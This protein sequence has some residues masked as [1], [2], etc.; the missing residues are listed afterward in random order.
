MALHVFTSDAQYEITAD[1]Q[2]D[3]QF[4]LDTAHPFFHANVPSLPTSLFPFLSRTP[5]YPLH[6]HTPV[7]LTPPEAQ[8]FFSHYFPQI[9][10]EVLSQWTLPLTL[11][12]DPVWPQPFQKPLFTYTVL[13]TPSFVGPLPTYP[14][15]IAH[16]LIVTSS[17]QPL[18]TPV[19]SENALSPTYYR[20]LI[21]ALLASIPPSWRSYLFVDNNKTPP[22]P[23]PL[24]NYGLSFPDA[25]KMLLQQE[26]AFQHIFLQYIPHA[27]LT[28]NAPPLNPKEHTAI[29]LALLLSRAYSE[30]RLQPLKP[31]NTRLNLYLEILQKIAH[32]MEYNAFAC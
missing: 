22:I 3:Y 16:R 14:R 23:S 32:E 4:S 29:N 11:H 5:D 18:Q 1:E 6:L 17:E 26:L 8:S 24:P 30:N 28:E 15:S 13:A 7:D 27:Y 10:P 2:D 31:F 19:F 25:L 9:P 20:T 12:T 21:I